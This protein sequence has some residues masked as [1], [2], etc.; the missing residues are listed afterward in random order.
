LLNQK[1]F[2]REKTRKEHE[3]AE[4]RASAKVKNNRLSRFSASFRG[5]I[6]LLFN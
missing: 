5:H 6:F 1:D 3:K 4:T 2:A